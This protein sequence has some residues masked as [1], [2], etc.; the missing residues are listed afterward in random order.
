MSLGGNTFQGSEVFRRRLDQGLLVLTSRTFLLELENDP[1]VRIDAG[2]R[3][4]ERIPRFGLG[5]VSDDL[6]TVILLRLIGINPRFLDFL[7]NPA[8]QARIVQRINF[9][10]PA[11]KK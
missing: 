3:K 10:I 4:E 6:F 1:L 2:L 7:S 9:P 5:K 8:D 11:I